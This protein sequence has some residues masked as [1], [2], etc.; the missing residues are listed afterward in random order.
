M[1]YS[2]SVAAADKGAVK[3]AAA[4]SGGFSG[5]VIAFTAAWGLGEQV[6][7]LMCYPSAAIGFERS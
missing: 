1:L 6:L 5:C 7:L 3:F 2:N 4:V